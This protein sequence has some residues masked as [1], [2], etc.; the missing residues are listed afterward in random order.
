MYMYRY[1][2]TPKP[3]GLEILFLFAKDTISEFLVHHD[4]EQVASDPIDHVFP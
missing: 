1:L 2:N 3:G 4:E